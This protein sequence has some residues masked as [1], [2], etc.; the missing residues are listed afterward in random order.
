MAAAD[1]PPSDCD[2]RI[3][4]VRNAIHG[5]LPA[6]D[7]TDIYTAELIVGALIDAGYLTEIA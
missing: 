6:D 3:L 4:I 1:E 2:P 7:L 5:P